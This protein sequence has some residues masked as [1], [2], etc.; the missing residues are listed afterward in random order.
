MPLTDFFVATPKELRDADPSKL[1]APFKTYRT[2]NVDAVELGTLNQILTKSADLPALVLEVS[3]EG[4]WIMRL[5]AGLTKAIG[6]LDDKSL[7]RI[8]ARWAKTEE[9]VRAGARGSDAEVILENLRALATGRD[10][11]NIYV[12]ACL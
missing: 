11:R 4:P 12:W 3:D 2:K 6:E 9:F 8:A 10:R 7:K 5:P 1:P